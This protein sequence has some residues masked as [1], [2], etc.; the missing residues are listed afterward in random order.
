M[1]IITDDF[2]R[3]LVQGIIDDVTDVA[4][5]YYIGI[6][7]SEEWNSTD[8]APTAANT[9]VEERNFR[10]SMQSIKKAEDVSYVIPRYNWV[11]GT[12]YSAYDNDQ[13]G[14]PENAYYVKTEENAVYICLEQGRNA[15]GEEVTSTVKPSGVATTPFRTAD[16]YV[17]KFLFTV[18]AAMA[19]SYLS[20]NYMPV[21]ILD[22]VTASDPAI[23]QEQFGIQNAAI[24]LS[25]SSIKVTD[26]G[27]DYTSAPTVNIVGNGTG[28]SAVA[29]VSGGSVVKVEMKDS[30]SGTL[31]VPGQDYQYANITFT[32]GGGSGAAATPTISPMAGF[33][34][35][36]MVDLKSTAMM[37]NT[38]PAGAENDDFIVGQDF[39]Q[40]GIIRNPLDASDAA[41]TSGTASALNYITLSAVTLNFTAD[42]TIVGGTTG[43]RAYVDSFDAATS[44]LYYHQA[45]ATG[46]TPFQ[47]GEAITE[48]NGSGSGVIGT[49][50]NIGDINKFTGE[51]FYIDNRAAI[52]RSDAQTEDLKVIIQL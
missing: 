40:V 12:S 23:D 2:K 49:T 29:S 28:A 16:G 42:K 32:G 48:T 37:F 50:A 21:R 45:D 18:G 4:Q 52:E 35:N 27:S 43:A 10:L 36:P 26:G 5:T 1:A 34:A 30:A 7:R 3:K 19:N 25:L 41:V 39:R 17:W 33:G 13:A 8:V 46:F 9:V 14:Y 51:I 11:S 24:P 31:Y 44:T 22:S 15:V 47:N 6:G 20:A 38:K